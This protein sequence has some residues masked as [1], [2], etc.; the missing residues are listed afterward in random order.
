MCGRS[1]KMAVLHVV[2]STPEHLHGRFQRSRNLGGFQ[3]VIDSEPTTE[4][5]AYQGD[6]H[7]YVCRGN[8][9]QLG[10]FFLQFIWRLRRRPNGAAIAN[11]RSSAVHR[12]DRSVRVKRIEISRAHRASDFTDA[13]FRFFLSRDNALLL[14]RFFQTRAMRSGIETISRLVAPFHRERGATFQRTPR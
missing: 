14:A 8:T 1:L 2:R 9:E 7:F 10:H 3:R 12:L 11:Y 5:T 6:V 13:L 4:A